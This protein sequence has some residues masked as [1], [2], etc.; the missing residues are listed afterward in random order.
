MLIFTIPI[1]CYSEEKMQDK[2]H[3]YLQK[4]YDEIDQPEI[5]VL[6]FVNYFHPNVSVWD[7]YIVGYIK[8]FYSRHEITY[9]LLNTYSRKFLSQKELDKA[10]DEVNN[11]DMTED[12]KDLHI[13]GYQQSYS[14]VQ[15]II[16]FASEK[17]HY[18]RCSRVTGIH[19][20]IETEDT[21]DDIVRKIKEDLEDI[22]KYDLE[23]KVFVDLRL[24][25]TLSRF[26]DFNKL[27]DYISKSL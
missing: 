1:Y 24:F 20:I 27:F 23:N 10:I 22:T 5:E 9:E 18:M 15:Y 2:Y 26:I 16:P 25:D 6:K 17:K 11:S 8:V 21:N 3:K 14:D 7:N 12:E 19:T 4:Y 13:R